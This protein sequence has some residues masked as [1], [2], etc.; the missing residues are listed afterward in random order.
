MCHEQKSEN[1]QNHNV[2]LSMPSPSQKQLYL[3]NRI[4]VAG[5]TQLQ[6][7]LTFQVLFH[8][9]NT[10]IDRV[11][12]VYVPRSP[13][14]PVTWTF[15]LQSWIVLF[16]YIISRQVAFDTFSRRHFT[17]CKCMNFDYNST[18]VCSKRPNERYSSIGA[19]NGLAPVRRQAIIWTNDG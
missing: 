6:L 18:E 3:R 4:L 1:F 17:E 7:F 5:A 9:D 15:G 13:G 16:C 19:N 14:K 2:T 8:L 12:T 11:T 10:K